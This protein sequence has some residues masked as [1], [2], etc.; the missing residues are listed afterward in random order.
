MRNT[1]MT[2]E[3]RKLNIDKGQFVMAYG[4]DVDYHDQTSE[5]TYLDR[6]TGKLLWIY[7]IDDDAYMMAGLSA[8]EN[9]QERERIAGEPSR[10]LEVPGLDHGDHHDILKMFLRSDWTE[11][12]E[13]WRMVGD[14][15]TGSIGRWKDDVGDRDVI[16][17][18][19]DFQDKTIGEMAE[20]FLLENLIEPV[21]K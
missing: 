17:A 1:G 16:H 7:E 21:W 3:I 12:E 18:F 13:R 4:R 9:R 15:Y 20:E 11:D 8:E 2:D 14:A 6:C 19:Y 10:F 5:A